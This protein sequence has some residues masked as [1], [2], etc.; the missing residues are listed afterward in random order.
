M[1]TRSA[2]R[3]ASNLL[4]AVFVA[5]AAMDMLHV[6][7]GFF[8]SY[9][10]D[11]SVPAWMYI[12]MRR[13]AMPRGNPNP[14]TRWIGLTP[15]RAAIALFLASAFTELTQIWWPHG[16]FSGTFDPLDIVAYGS[17]LLACFFFDVR[18]SNAALPA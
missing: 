8:T 18:S 1:T 5:A 12:V 13:L 9:A 17:G 16:V 7:G 4:L 3:L 10:A 14:L 11:V 2:W 6:D 15:A